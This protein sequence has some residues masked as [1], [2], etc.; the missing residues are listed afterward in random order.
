MVDSKIRPKIELLSP[1]GSLATL[2]AAVASGADA[3]YLGMNKFNARENASNFNRDYFME[4]IKICKS[5]NV[6]TYFTANTLI[7]NSE[8]ADF[9]DQLNYAYECGID[10]VIIQDPS[11][12]EIIRKTFPGLSIHMSTQTGIMNSA[13]ANLFKEI[14]RI[15]LARELSKNNIGIIRKK[16]EKELEIFVHGALCACVSGSCLFSS[17][18]GGRS[19]NRGKCA[20]PCRKLYSGS[21]VLSTKELCLIDKIPE[22]IGLGINSLKIEGRM[23]T[24]YYVA[25]V[26][27]NYRK[28]IASYYAKKFSVTP[29][30]KD[31][32]KSAF[33]RDFTQGKFANEEIFNLK[34]SSGT[35]KAYKKIYD[36]KINDINIKKRKANFLKL[37]F[38]KKASSGKQ[39]IVRV[40]NE[41]DALIADKYADIVCLD[42]FNKNFELL[43]KK[44]TKPLYAV[45]QRIMLE[46]DIDSIKSKISEINPAGILAGNLGILNFNLKCPIILDY[47]SNC[48][49]DAGVEYYQTLGAKPIIATELSLAELENFRNKDFVVFVHG[50]IRLMTLVHS[51]NEAKIKDWKGFNFYIKKIPNGSQVF[52]EKEL[53]LFNKIRS[54]RKSGINQIYLDPNSDE[55]LEKILKTYRD[56]LEGKSLDV[57]ELQREYVLGWS[58]QGVL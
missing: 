6:R 10:A 33:S 27:S 12:I 23:R 28:A 54:I 50:K 17:L 24:P 41:K 1:A 8:L 51:L 44:L 4:A 49:N 29:S 40:Y 46:Q 58:K 31:E 22:I 5:N 2:K 20:Q 9:F 11:F 35:S 32:L 53:G 52:N 45:T 57:S 25:T 7:K 3:V 48:F 42:L 21:Y 34:Q 55:N 18:L 47:N 37:E 38:D 56:I 15:N 19:G 30:M 14:E 36:V 16:F 13:H 43:Q 26:T 39:M